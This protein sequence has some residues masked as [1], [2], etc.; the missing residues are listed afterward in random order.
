MGVVVSVISSLIIINNEL[1]PKQPQVKCDQFNCS[2][3]YNYNRDP[4]DFIVQSV[5]LFW[6]I[7][8]DEIAM[9]RGL[10]HEMQHTRAYLYC[11]KKIKYFFKTG[12]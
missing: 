4:A 9:F 12:I 10:G 1:Q 11:E 6:I 2:N 7:A 5:L 8:G 3:Y